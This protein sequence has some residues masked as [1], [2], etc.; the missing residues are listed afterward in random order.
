MTTSGDTSAI[1]QNSEQ[2]RFIEKQY[3]IS[4]GKFIRILL[5]KMTQSFLIWVGDAESQA[6]IDNLSLGIGK[7]STVILGTSQ[8]DLLSAKVASR[9]SMKFNEK[10]PVY[11]SYNLKP[12][13]ISEE[14]LSLKINEKLIEFC[15]EYMPKDT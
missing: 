5:I 8:F 1:L 3:E 15:N 14:Q 7:Q 10:R 6:Q 13:V 12:G 11:V 4:P 9:L 2:N